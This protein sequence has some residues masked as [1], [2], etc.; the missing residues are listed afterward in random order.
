[1]PAN[2]TA[3]ASGLAASS[4]SKGVKARLQ[5]LNDLDRRTKSA[6]RVFQ[7]RDDLIAD[8]GGRDRLSVMEMQLI[9]NSALL[10]AMLQ[11]AATSYL[12]GEP[13]DLMEFQTLTNAQR[14]LLSD[15]G[16]QRRMRDVEPDI[17]SYLK[18]RTSSEAA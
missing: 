8:L 4:P 13:I 11:D 3:D 6:Q 14:R 18:R 5:S 12:Q 2:S 15:L 1:M 17:Q 16:L 9:D 7:L 10:G